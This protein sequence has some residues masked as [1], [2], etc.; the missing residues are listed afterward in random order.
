MLKKSTAKGNSSN[1]NNFTIVGNVSVTK[2][3]QKM[4]EE[5]DQNVIEMLQESDIKLQL[6]VTLKDSELVLKK[7]DSLIVSLQQPKEKDQDWVVGKVLVSN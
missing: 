1:E 3:T 4:Y 2:T 7:G 5:N 6:Y